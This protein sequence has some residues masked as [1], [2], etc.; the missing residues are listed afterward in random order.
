VEVNHSQINKELWFTLI[1]I[2]QGV[3]LATLFVSASPAPYFVI[4]KH[5]KTFFKTLL[6]VIEFIVFSFPPKVSMGSRND[7]T[8]V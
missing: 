5:P 7:S 8:M 2:Q 1:P 6:A 4:K 3:L